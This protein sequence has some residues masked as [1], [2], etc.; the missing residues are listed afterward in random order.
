MQMCMNWQAISF[1]WN[2]V[3]A[4]LATAEEGSF[5]GGARVL[6]LT[7]PTLGR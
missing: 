7:Q 4:F 3:R 6:G 2:Q 5:S 1:D